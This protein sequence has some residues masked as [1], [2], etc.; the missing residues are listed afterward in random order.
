MPELA[1]PV[2]LAVTELLANVLR[3]VPDRRC[4]LLVLRQPYS[5]RVQV[6]DSSAGLPTVSAP[7]SDSEGGR[8]L[9]LVEAMADEW[10]GG[11]DRRRQDGVVRM[12]YGQGHLTSRHHG[13]R[14]TEWPARSSGRTPLAHWSG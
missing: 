14:H 9:V 11:A 6:S 5:V 2:G 3:H 7:D 4:E 12:R 10:G 1:D 8:G 13:T